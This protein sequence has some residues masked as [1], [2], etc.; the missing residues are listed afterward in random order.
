M[1]KVGIWLDQKEANVITLS[2]NTQQNKIIY[3]KNVI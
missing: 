3:S 1:K 2:E